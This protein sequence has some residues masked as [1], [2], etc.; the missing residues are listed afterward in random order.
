MLRFPGSGT[1]YP[2]APGHAALVA[3]EAID[4]SAISPWQPDLS[5][6][7]FEW[8]VGVNNPDVPNLQDIGPSPLS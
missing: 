5:H 4:H 1:D 2:L 7:D 3:K 6:A 8:P